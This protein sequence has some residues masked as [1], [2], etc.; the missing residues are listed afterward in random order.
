MEQRRVC[1]CVCVCVRRGRFK[2]QRAERLA[3]W[4]RTWPGVGSAPYGSGDCATVVL[5]GRQATSA[6]PFC[7]DHT[8]RGDSAMWTI[9]PEPW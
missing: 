6:V 7:G 5:A 8:P 9:A 3:L 2:C 1:V 4:A